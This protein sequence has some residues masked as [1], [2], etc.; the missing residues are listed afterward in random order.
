MCLQISKVFKYKFFI[1]NENLIN[2]KSMIIQ[3]NIS[4]QILLIILLYLFKVDFY[5]LSFNI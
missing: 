5:A 1:F 2:A 3:G 4:K